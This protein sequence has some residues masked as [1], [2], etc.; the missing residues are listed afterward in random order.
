MQNEW[1]FRMSIRYW[2][3]VSALML[4]A[5]AGVF[6]GAQTERIRNEKVVVVE[7]TLASGE[8]CV[9]TVGRAGVVVYLDAGAIEATPVNEKVR[10][11]TVKRGDTVFQSPQGGTVKNVGTSA[12]RIVRVEYAGTGSSENWGTAGLARDYRLL[13]ENR[14]GRV[15]DIRIGAGESEPQHSHHDR[16]VICLSG[17]DLEHILPDGRKETS[18]LKTGEIAW[19]RGGTHVGHNLGTT[20]LWVI[21]VEPK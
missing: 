5:V 14:Y 18:T 2:S 12:L 1:R 17:A 21:A 15:S 20:D 16:V 11:V 13:F 10:R 8:V 9:P 6:A 3:G 7:Q 19:R 4:F